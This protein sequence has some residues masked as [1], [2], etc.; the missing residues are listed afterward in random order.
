MGDLREHRFGPGWGRMCRKKCQGRHMLE[1]AQG[2]GIG[3][4]GWFQSHQTE[5]DNIQGR[6]G[7]ESQ[8]DND[9]KVLHKL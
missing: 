2:R 5:K 9:E 6:I 8:Q 3:A 1:R 7:R 4:N